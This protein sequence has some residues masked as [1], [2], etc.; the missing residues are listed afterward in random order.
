MFGKF[1]EAFECGRDCGEEYRHQYD[2]LE[3]CAKCVFACE[4]TNEN[5]PKNI[6]DIIYKLA[7]EGCAKAVEQPRG[8]SEEVSGAQDIQVSAFKLLKNG[9]SLKIVY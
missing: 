1:N 2:K 8:G 9:I 6:A 3:D 4:P 5:Q 7:R